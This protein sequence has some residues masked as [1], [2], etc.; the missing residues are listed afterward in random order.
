MTLFLLILASY[1]A[2]GI[3]FAIPFITIGIAHIDPAARHAPLSFRLLILPGVAALWPLLL[4]R[5]IRRA[6]APQ[7]PRESTRSINTL[8]R[9]HFNLWLFLGP[10][11]LTALILLITLRP[12]TGPGAH[13]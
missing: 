12:G 11:L 5:W 13:S 1:L 2:L 3:L 10:A 7:W 8:R 6:P 4:L 9:L